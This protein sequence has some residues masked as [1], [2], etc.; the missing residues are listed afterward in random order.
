MKSQL[1]QLKCFGF[2]STVP[3]IAE[4]VVLYLNRTD[5][6]DVK[7]ALLLSIIPTVSLVAIFIY[8]F[9]ILL[10]NY[11]ATKSQLLQIELRK[12]LCRFIQHYS[13]YSS[14][15][16]QQDQDAL[17]KFENVIFS[18]IVSDEEK[19]PSS[20]DGIEQLGSLIKSIK[21]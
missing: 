9:R 11:K 10:Y 2:L 17:S 3:L 5:L 8:Y 6:S 7:H 21:S 18:G 19:L 16:K 20:Y 13:E 1:L 4:M 14:K 15:L 12:T